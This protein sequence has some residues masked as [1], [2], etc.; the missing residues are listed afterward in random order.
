MSVFKVELSP[1]P[2]AGPA[3]NGVVGT[4]SG[5][6]IKPHFWFENAF[7]IIAQ[8]FSV[9]ALGQMAN[10]LVALLTPAAVV[11]FV[12]GLW[13]VATDLG[14]AGAFLISGGLF[15]HW[16]VWI[17]LAIALKIL[18]STLIAWGARTGKFSEEN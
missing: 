10:V 2:A 18:S 8:D 12:M 16:Q 7:A 13:R 3:Q 6:S 15:S 5:A 11:A 14:W 4:S 9:E 17:A 1:Q